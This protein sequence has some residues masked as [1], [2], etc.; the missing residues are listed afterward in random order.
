MRQGRL[1]G[2]QS[3][4]QQQRRRQQRRQQP[5][6]C[7]PRRGRERRCAAR[8]KERPASIAATRRPCLRPSEPCA[9]T[10]A[11]R[12]RLPSRSPARRLT[13]PAHR[14]SD[15][16]TFL[17]GVNIPFD[18]TAGK[19]PIIADPIRTMEVRAAGQGGAGLGCGAAAGAAADACAT[20][21][22]ARAGASRVPAA[23]PLRPPQQVDKMTQLDPEAVTPFV[24][25]ALRRLRAEVRPRAGSQLGWAGVR[26]PRATPV[27]SRR[28]VDGGRQ[29]LE[30][31]PACRRRPSAGGSA[32]PH[33]P[34]LLPAAARP[35]V[36]NA[37][38]VLGFVGA[39]FTLATYIVE[40]A[41][42]LCSCPEAA[43]RW[44]LAGVQGS[45]HACIARH[46]GHLR[47]RACAARAGRALRR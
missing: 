14:R 2:G 8:R 30:G 15:I 47:R 29:L 20:L 10:C 26:S 12:L 44:W 21:G 39:P 5:W 45:V 37:S 33:K 17:P 24:G 4:Q 34:P 19:G 35:Q 6:G 13:P 9:A 42:R 23:A 3:A 40:G 41:W 25:E 22:G 27:A 38:T 16:L 36:G 43:L 7:K 31:W 46:A 18:I 28:A 1:T 11:A 32:L